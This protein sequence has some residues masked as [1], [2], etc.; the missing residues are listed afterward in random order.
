MA[1]LLT[2]RTLPYA[3]I[4]ANR[5]AS[6]RR[7][8]DENTPVLSVAR[9]FPGFSPDDVSNGSSLYRTFAF[10][11]ADNTGIG[12]RRNLRRKDGG[13]RLVR[14]SRGGFNGSL[15]FGQHERHRTGERR[16]G[17]VRFVPFSEWP[18]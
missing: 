5:A 10:D 3:I 4:P 12:C 16:Q 15:A 13:H 11:C 8:S 2:C 9:R 1:W 17:T 18:P 14:E 7:T 6:Q